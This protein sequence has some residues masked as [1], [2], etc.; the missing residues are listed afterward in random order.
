M[1][2]P[3][4]RHGRNA[5]Q[6]T[7]PPQNQVSGGLGTPLTWLPVIVALGPPGTERSGPVCPS[8]LL[9]AITKDDR[10]T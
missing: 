6:E 8:D 2:A 3:N 4:P 1:T 7:I 9:S 5:G 10:S